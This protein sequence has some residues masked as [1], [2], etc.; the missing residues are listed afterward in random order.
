MHPCAPPPLCIIS[1]SFLE[2]PFSSLLCPASISPVQPLLPPPPV[3]LLTPFQWEFHLSRLSLSLSLVRYFSNGSVYRFFTP[4]LPLPSTPASLLISGR[5]A[6]YETDLTIYAINWQLFRKENASGRG[7]EGGPP[8]IA[9][10]HT[11]TH[12]R[13]STEGCVFVCDMK[14]REGGRMKD[15][16]ETHTLKKIGRLPHRS[17]CV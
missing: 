2:A 7:R 14:R 10:R 5:H 16:S 12:N 13:G 17:A 3:F 15:D 6:N 1:C 11:L 4:S 8:H 9:H